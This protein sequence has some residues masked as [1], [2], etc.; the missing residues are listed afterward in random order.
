M[1]D[2][3]ADESFSEAV[4]KMK[5]HYG[6]NVS[7][8]AVQRITVQHAEII[9]G[10]EDA[11]H[12]ERL[13]KRDNIVDTTITE[14]DGSMVPIVEFIIPSDKTES[15]V[16]LRKCRT[17]LYKEAR[18]A[19]SHEQGSMTPVYAATM[20][21]VNEAGKHLR[22]TVEAVGLSDKTRIHGVGDGALW[23]ANQFEKQFGAQSSYLIDFYHLCEYLAAASKH[24]PN[25][26]SWVDQQKSFLKNSQPEQVLIELKPYLEPST[27]ADEQAPVR[28]CYRY[29]ENRPG[30]FNY[31]E[32]IEKGLPIGSGEVESE[33]RYISQKRLK[34]PGAWWKKT[35][36]ANMLSLRV[37]RANGHW[38]SYWSNKRLEAA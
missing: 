20:G 17:L 35:N 22:F 19:L 1:T 32:T 31:K 30:Q 38:Q 23:I 24:I 21:D 26:Q 2:F 14:I 18:L 11:C 33:H 15:E 7:T 8:T 27:T 28:A 4:S 16:D 9:H 6:I 10:S 12:Q 36:A 25:S 34:V 3:G 13:S 37:Q 29:I 5:E